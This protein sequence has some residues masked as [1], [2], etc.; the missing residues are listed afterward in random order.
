MRQ[1]SSGRSRRR[2]Q[3]SGSSGGPGLGPC[4]TA[5]PHTR[6]V[7]AGLGTGTLGPCGSDSDGGSWASLCQPS[8]SAQPHLVG[9]CCHR[10]GLCWGLMGSHGC[11]LL[12]GA[13]CKLEGVRHSPCSTQ[14]PAWGQPCHGHV[15]GS[16]AAVKNP[17]PQGLWSCTRPLQ[18]VTGVCAAACPLVPQLGG[19]MLGHSRSSMEVTKAVWVATEAGPA[20]WGLLGDTLHNSAL[21]HVE[22]STVS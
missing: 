6:M 3:R 19:A 1:Q 21:G 4:T 5:P 12:C 22:I 7:S 13:G 11:S 18:A 9:S 14:R 2:G 20:P 16:P 8:N 17:W 10:S 15:A